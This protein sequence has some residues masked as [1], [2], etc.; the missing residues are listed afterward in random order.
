MGKMISCAF[1]VFF[2]HLNKVFA[3]QITVWKS[4][5]DISTVT[6]DR[7]YTVLWLQ[8]VG[9]GL[10]IFFEIITFVAI[11]CSNSANLTS[12]SRM[13]RLLSWPALLVVF[14]HNWIQFF[15][16][17]CALVKADFEYDGLF[18]FFCRFILWPGMA[19]SLFR[20]SGITW[21]L[22]WG[23]LCEAYGFLVYWPL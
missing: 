5:V 7:A 2:W 21:I 17:Q 20:H 6:S 8:T 9:P 1:K 16:M 19:Q 3:F 22:G 18:A 10:T 11:E 14:H 13:V 12:A 4:L 15:T 23:V